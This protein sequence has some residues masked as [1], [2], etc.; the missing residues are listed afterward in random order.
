MA[1]YTSRIQV[2]CIIAEVLPNKDEHLAALK[3]LRKLSDA[4]EIVG[5]PKNPRLFQVK[6][7]AITHFE[8]FRSNLNKEEVALF[9]DIEHLTSLDFARQFSKQYRRAAEK[10]TPLDTLIVTL[11]KEIQ[12]SHEVRSH[13][14]P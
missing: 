14:T 13:P 12:A 4:M 9:S 3:Q 6:D 10:E 2:M 7:K 8:T 11:T 5:H 1:T